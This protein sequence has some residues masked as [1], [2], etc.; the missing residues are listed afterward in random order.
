MSKHELNKDDTNKH[1]KQDEEKSQGLD[2]IYR[3]IGT[4]KS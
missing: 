2:F 4:F 3:I 1:A